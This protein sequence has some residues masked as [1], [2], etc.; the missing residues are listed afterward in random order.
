MGKKNKN[1]IKIVFR[2]DPPCTDCYRSE[3]RFLLKYSVVYTRTIKETKIVRTV[4]FHVHD[5][6]NILADDTMPSIKKKKNCCK[7]NWSLPLRTMFDI[8]SSI[9]QN[10]R[11]SVLLCTNLKVKSSKKTKKANN[12]YSGT[13]G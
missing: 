8:F 12:N 2:F 5:G 4:S 11:R 9:D 10:G 3:I 7:C 6:G 13:S 1:K